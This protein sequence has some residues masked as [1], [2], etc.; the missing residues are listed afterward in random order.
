MQ[1]SLADNFS[2]VRGC[3][4]E[5]TGTPCYRAMAALTSD[6]IARFVLIVTYAQIHSC[7]Q[8]HFELRPSLVA[9]NLARA[10]IAREQEACVR[11]GRTFKVRIA[12]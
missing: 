3:A 12:A 9:T 10:M 5:F 6:C 11:Q 2:C 8:Q 1:D 7:Q 4:V